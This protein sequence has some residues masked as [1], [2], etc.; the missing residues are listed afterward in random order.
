MFWSRRHLSACDRVHIHIPDGAVS[1]VREEMAAGMNLDDFRAD[2]RRE[3][4]RAAARGEQYAV[5]L[6]LDVVW[7]VGAP[8]PFLIS[9]G[10]R[11]RSAPA[12][13]RTAFGH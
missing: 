7:D 9:D 8:L 2:L 4:Q 1:F 13:T 10:G 11:S 3:R 6:D 5:E 12:V